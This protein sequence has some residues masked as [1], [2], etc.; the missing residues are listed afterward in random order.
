GDP[1]IGELEPR[2]V[3]RARPSAPRAAAED[4]LGEVEPEPRGRRE[5]LRAVERDHEV[6][7]LDLAFLW[8]LVPSRQRASQHHPAITVTLLERRGWS[9]R[10]V[11][12]SIELLPRQEAA[13]PAGSFG[14]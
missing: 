8:P 4:D 14:P 10:S 11:Q 6:L 12:P 2:D 5:W 9:G 7:G 3:A 1:C 13:L